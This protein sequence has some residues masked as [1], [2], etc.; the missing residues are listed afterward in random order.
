MKGQM[1]TKHP[2]LLPQANGSVEL[3]RKLSPTADGGTQLSKD[4]KK[5]R[6][7]LGGT[8]ATLRS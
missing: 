6:T 8:L 1:E 5:R 7:A 4:W 3:I 2:S